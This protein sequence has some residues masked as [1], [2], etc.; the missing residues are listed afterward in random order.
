MY[1]REW[2]AGEISTALASGRFVTIRDALPTE[3]A[4]SLYAEAAAVQTDPALAFR[5]K[6]EDQK[7]IGQAAQATPNRSHFSEPKLQ[8]LYSAVQS[9]GRKSQTTPVVKGLTKNERLRCCSYGSTPSLLHPPKIYYPSL[10][11]ELES[12]LAS[13]S[14]CQGALDAYDQRFQFEVHGT[15]YHSI[16]ADPDAGYPHDSLPMVEWLEK[17]CN[18]S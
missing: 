10:D 6:S 11:G 17:V 7:Y 15:S 5:R 8:E 2:H 4:K 12:A 9:A 1:L 18:P 14:M 3:L 16:A 13:L